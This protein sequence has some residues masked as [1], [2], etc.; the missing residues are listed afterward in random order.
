MFFDAM[1]SGIAYLVAALVL[2]ILGKFAY[3]ITHP[4]FSLRQQLIERD[5]LALAMSMGGYF[6]GLSIAVGGA[7]AGAPTSLGADLIGISLYGAIAIVLLNL[8]VRI[9]DWLILY[10]VSGEKEILEDQNCGVGMIEAANHIAMGLIIYGIISGEGGGILAVLVFWLLGQA[11]L[12]VAARLYG[13]L[14]RYNIQDAIEK[15]N[16]AVGVAFSGMILAIGNV[17][18]FA[19][20]GE[21]VSWQKSL[22]SY[23]VVVVFGLLALPLVRLATDKLI[24]PGKRLTAELVYQENPNIGA[25]VIEGVVY[26]SMSILIGWCII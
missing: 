4:G 8:S 26:V 11:T 15:G 18:R 23:A 10:R 19:E 1:L 25:G 13:W 24:L 6:L 22:I 21:F 14:V 2:F 9:N 5:N 3:D 17:I 12:I 20:Q 16:V 7:L